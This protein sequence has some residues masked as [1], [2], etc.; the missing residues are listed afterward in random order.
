MGIASG[1]SEWKLLRVRV[2]LSELL[3]NAVAFN[4]KE[5]FTLESQNP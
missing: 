2:V 3:L 1:V 5:G 4:I